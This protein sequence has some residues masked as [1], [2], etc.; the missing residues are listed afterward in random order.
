MYTFHEFFPT[1]TK[2]FRTFK[3]ILLNM[4]RIWGHS[5]CAPIKNKKQEQKK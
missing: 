1:Q 5:R 2:V 4:R 3:N